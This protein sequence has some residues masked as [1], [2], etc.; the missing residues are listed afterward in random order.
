MTSVCCKMMCISRIIICMDWDK[1]G[2]EKSNK[3]L[4]FQHRTSLENGNGIGRRCG[5]RTR[6][7]ETQKESASVFRRQNRQVQRG[8]DYHVVEGWCR[9]Q[10]GR[11]FP[12]FVHA[13]E[14]IRVSGVDLPQGHTR[15]HVARRRFHQTRRNGRKIHLRAEISGWEFPV[16]A[17][18]PR[19]LVH[20]QFRTGHQRIAVLHHGGKDRLAG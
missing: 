11:E 3:S 18:R 7:E 12:G 13:R 5:R 15:L 10:N 1:W 19:H 2:L 14:G 4:N 6:G 16:E 8:P 17:R 20:G 9:A